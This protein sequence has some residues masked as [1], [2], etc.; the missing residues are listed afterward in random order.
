MVLDVWEHAYYVDYK[1]ERAK[2]VEAFWNIVNWDYVN[3][4]LNLVK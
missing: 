1:N 4:T 3:K 2:F